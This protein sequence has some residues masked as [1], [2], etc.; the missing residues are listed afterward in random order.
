[1][2]NGASLMIVV[3]SL[4]LSEKFNETP[5]KVMFEL[6]RVRITVPLVRLCKQDVKVGRRVLG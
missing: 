3:I 2:L 5:I 1:M 6:A 4:N